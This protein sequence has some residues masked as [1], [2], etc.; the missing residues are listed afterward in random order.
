MQ[1]L[2]VIVWEYYISQAHNLKKK[3]DTNYNFVQVLL[4]IWKCVW[5]FEANP[6]WSYGKHVWNLFGGV[7]KLY[8]L[9]RRTSSVYQ[10]SLVIHRRVT[11]ILYS[12]SKQL[13]GLLRE[14]R[15]CTNTATTVSRTSDAPPHAQLCVPSSLFTFR[16][17][18]RSAWED[19][20]RFK[21]QK[22]HDLRE[23]LISYAIM[24]ISLCKKVWRPIWIL[25][26]SQV[27]FQDPITKAGWLHC[28]H[29][30]NSYYLLFSGNPGVVQCQGVLQQNVSYFP[31]REAKR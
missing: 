12:A 9:G 26:L 10:W 22:D 24:Q 16:E 6:W 25:S 15:N 1:Y 3:K 21:A 23:A 17:F 19:I 8:C 20:E 31:S 4:V 29:F 30:P 13:L 5:R 7:V 2:H 14:K 27:I 28:H 18:V 11:H